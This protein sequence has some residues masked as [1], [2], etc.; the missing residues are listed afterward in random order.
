MSQRGGEGKRIW[1]LYLF[2]ADFGPGGVALSE[3]LTD[4]GRGGQGACFPQVPVPG[5]S[6]RP[7]L[8]GARSPRVA[9][10][11]GGSTRTLVCGRTHVQSNLRR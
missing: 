9:A 4:A 11:D 5:P 3:T 10:T 8:K 6:A 1:G 2:W 7:N